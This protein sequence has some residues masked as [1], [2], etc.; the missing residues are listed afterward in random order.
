A[1]IAQVVLWLIVVGVFLASGQASLF[2]P[3]SVYLVF[4]LLVFVLRPILVRSFGFDANWN[5]MIFEPTDAYFMKTLAVS[6]VALVVFT[7]ASMATGWAR[8][9]FDA[10]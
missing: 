7:A 4:Y 3:A 8:P 10:G 1:L 5:Y 2:H 9:V 6:S